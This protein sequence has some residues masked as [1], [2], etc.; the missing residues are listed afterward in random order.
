MSLLGDPFRRDYGTLSDEQKVSMDRCKAVYE[1]T[2]LEL[3]VLEG[4][5][6]KR[7]DLSLARTHLQESCMWAVR[8]ITKMAG[9]E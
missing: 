9:Q 5:F 7:Q 8:A 1:Q 6:D 4:T 2:W 3:N